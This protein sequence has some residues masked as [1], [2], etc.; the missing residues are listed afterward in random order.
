MQRIFRFINKGA[1]SIKCELLQDC[2]NRLEIDDLI[3]KKKRGKNALFF[4]NLVL[5]VSNKNDKP[6]SVERVHKSP[7]SPKAIEK[8]ESFADHDLGN[9]KNVTQSMHLINTPL[10]YRKD[11]SGGHS[12]NVCT[13]DRK[14]V[15]KESAG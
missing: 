14:S 1:Q 15:F 11:N 4:I 2:M 3:H 7:E 12:S 5:S 13:N 10:L 9:I 8:L 6:D